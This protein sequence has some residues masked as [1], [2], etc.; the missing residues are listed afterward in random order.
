MYS[1]WLKLDVMMPTRGSEI[2][3]MPPVRIRWT[4]SV[5]P[6]WAATIHMRSCQDVPIERM[7]LKRDRLDVVLLHG[8][9]TRLSAELFSPL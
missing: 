9:R 6:P 5:R 8:S 1:P 4:T 2:L 7:I 3:M